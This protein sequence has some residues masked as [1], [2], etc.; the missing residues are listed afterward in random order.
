M[1]KII[2]NF[3]EPDYANTLEDFFI[4]KVPWYF[5]ENNSV[6]GEK[7]T[8]DSYGFF[9]VF[10]VHGKYTN[11]PYLKTVEPLIENIRKEIGYSK[12]LRV[13]GDLTVYQNQ[14]K[15]FDPH[16]DFIPG[17]EGVSYNHMTAIYYVNDSSGDTV[18]FKERCKGI[19]D[20]F[21]RDVKD[22]T[23]DKQVTPKKNRL[24]YF[25]GNIVHTGYAPL[26]HS[27]R[28]LIN[29]NFDN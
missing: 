21:A 1:I 29:L 2:D 3:L 24:V 11:T 15:I 4:K 27:N 10:A 26:E 18:F 14:K 25:D 22:L 5:I 20:P 9:H 16:T 7:E 28:I 8:V 13:R 12:I 6:K 19:N 23:V 17:H